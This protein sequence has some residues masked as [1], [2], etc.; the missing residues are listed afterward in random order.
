MLRWLAWALAALVIAVAVIVGFGYLRGRDTTHLR[1]GDSVPDVTL[2]PVEGTAPARLRE[3]LGAAT[4]V[5]FFDTR[6]TPMT[7][8][9]EVLE[10][11]YRRYQRRG[12]R[13]IGIAL[14]D[15]RDAVRDFIHKNAITFTVLHDPG[16]RATEPQWGRATG[17][18]SYLIDATG[19]V[20]ASYPEPVDWRADE[21]RLKVE[22]LL[23]SPPPGAW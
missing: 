13:M 23:P 10:R 7:R 2:V 6:W 5:V 18:A 11:L 1:P 17:P 9:A 12:L 15:S 8:Y 16:G 22:S 20:V 21:R 19:R 3:N 14:D 4:V